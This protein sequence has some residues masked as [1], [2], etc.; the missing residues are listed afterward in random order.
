MKISLLD[1]VFTAV[2]W[3][4]SSLGYTPVSHLDTA[5]SCSVQP[6]PEYNTSVFQPI[7]SAPVSKQKPVLLKPEPIHAQ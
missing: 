3:L 5:G 1:G 4:L 6:N 2:M 7:S